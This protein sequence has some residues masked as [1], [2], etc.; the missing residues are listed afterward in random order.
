MDSNRRDFVRT[1]IGAALGGAL[2]PFD[3]TAFAADDTTLV[4]TALADGVVQ[5]AGAGGNILV[6]E[7]PEGLLLVNGGAPAR[8][9]DVTR[10]L[11]ER[12]PG[13]AVRMLFNTDWHLHNTGY[14][15]TA[16]QAGATIVSHVNTRLYMSTTVD[17]RWEDRTY[18][19]RAKVALP[20]KT[21]YTD[22]EMTFGAQR[23]VY[24]YLGQAH[25]DGDIFVH[26]PGPNILAAGDLVTVGSYPIP[27][28]SCGGWVVGL[29]NGTRT[30]LNA[31]QEGARILPGQ[32][33][34][35]TR[36]HL[37]AQHRMLSS[38]S[39]RLI[40]MMRKGM[41]PEDMRAAAPTK[42]FDAQWGDPSVFM[43]TVYP[44]LWWHAREVGRVI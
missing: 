23:V 19:P 20:A 40:G 8:A 9:A 15:D 21:F 18:T 30:L 13:K 39:D 2:L 41:G 6:L 27:D 12:F 1:V 32:G 26:L 44:G 24:G 4:A 5:I 29:A 42:E 25:T 34:V 3:G 7:Q 11:A 35:Q 36:A 10:L 33:P 16:G 31:T 37:E 17:V 22:G 43:N 28:Y 38:M 14:N